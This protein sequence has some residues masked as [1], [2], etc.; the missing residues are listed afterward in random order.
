MITLD[1]SEVTEPQT[2]PSHFPRLHLRPDSV[3][4]SSLIKQ[5]ISDKGPALDKLGKKREHK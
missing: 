1:P 2:C 5:A 3:P 4:L